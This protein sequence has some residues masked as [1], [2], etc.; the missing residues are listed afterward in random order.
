MTPKIASLLSLSLVLLLLLCGTATSSALSANDA[1]TQHSPSIHS[2]STLTA[3][4]TTT[5][6]SLSLLLSS[7]LPAKNGFKGLIDQVLVSTETG[8]SSLL[9]DDFGPAAAEKGGD[10]A[11]TMKIINN[12][13][14][15]G[16]MPINAAS[17]SSLLSP[18]SSSQQS[19]STA[20]ASASRFCHRRVDWGLM[21]L[22][23]KRLHRQPFR[24]DP[25]SLLRYA[26]IA[27]VHWLVRAVFFVPRLVCSAFVEYDDTYMTLILAGASVFCSLSTRRRSVPV[28]THIVK[29]VA[30]VCCMWLPFMEGA[31]FWM[32]IMVG[33]ALVA[34]R[35]QRI[36]PDPE[37]VW[38]MVVCSPSS[39]SCCS[40]DTSAKQSV[41]QQTSSDTEFVLLMV[42][43]S[44][45]SAPSV[46]T[47]AKHFGCQP[48]TEDRY[49]I[50]I[51][52][53]RN[54]GGSTTIDVRSSD[55]LDSVLKK[56]QVRM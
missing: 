35:C 54:N 38:L 16:W 6:S 37:L 13:L 23:R 28:F 26:C 14:V 46:A 47:P 3:N 18:F 34:W 24:L 15:F 12:N 49:S 5:S 17:S 25:R 27:C 11:T 45:S 1:T 33:A 9:G 30:A 32:A 55:T 36:S 56:L 31:Q 22:P 44:P 8:A 7:T 48:D 20:P 41:C 29:V 21:Y 50:F 40:V 2:S 43:G 10:N 51:L 39:S 42:V 19:S 53:A 52:S 4:D